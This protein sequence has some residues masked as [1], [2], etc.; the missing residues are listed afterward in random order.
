VGPSTWDGM[1]PAAKARR[2]LQ[3]SRTASMPPF[4]AVQ[5]ATLVDSVPVGS[6]WLHEMKY[7]GYRCLL[8][9]GGGG[10]RA[11]T[12]SALTG[13]ITFPGSPKQRAGFE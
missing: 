3:S 1:R 11:Y 4:R 12:R 2:E 13:P 8:A 5:L 9:I 6:G 10:A 7:D